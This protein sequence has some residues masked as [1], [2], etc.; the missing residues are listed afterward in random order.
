MILELKGPPRDGLRWR[1][2][3]SEGDTCIG[4]ISLLAQATSAR[5]VTSE[6]VKVFGGLDRREIRMT[7][8]VMPEA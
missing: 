4:P 8:W 5:R 2:V 6:D 1:Y 7:E 3:S